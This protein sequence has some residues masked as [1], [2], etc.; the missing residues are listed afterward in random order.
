MPKQ[1]IRSVEVR[2]FRNISYA[3]ADFSKEINIIYCEN[4]QGKTNFIEAV[5]LLSGG[6]SFRGTKDRD[7]I[8]IGKEQFRI[9][10]IVRGAGG[11]E[12]ITVACSN[13][14]PKFQSRM[15]KLDTGDFLAPGK[16][17]GNFYSGE[18]ITQ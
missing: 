8:G 11:D 4:R 18:K 13:K 9:E 7:M 12:K 3:K 15:A 17:V 10:G 1:Y 16:I 5:W 14:N 6:K 2:D